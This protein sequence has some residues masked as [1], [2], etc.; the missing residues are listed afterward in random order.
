VTA[1][2]E[3]RR[4]PAQSE[5]RKAHTLLRDF[6]DQY[7]A[8]L[9]MALKAGEPFLAGVHCP[10]DFDKL[11]AAQWRKFR[12]GCHRGFDRA[13]A[14]VLRMLTDNG[15]NA[16][17]SDSTRE[18][19]ELLLRKVTDSIAFQMLGGKIHVFRT[20]TIL[21]A[22]PTIDLD[23]A[24]RNLTVAQKMNADSR[25]A[26]ALV[27]DLSASLHIG[28]LL[29]ISWEG[30]ARWDV[31]ELKSGVVNQI[32]IGY[33]DDVEPTIESVDRVRA[34]SDLS[35]GMRKQAV[36]MLKQR[37]RMQQLSNL[38][39]FEEGTDPRTQ[40]PFRFSHHES[41][42]DSYDSA[43]NEVC[44]GAMKSG[45]A[46]ASVD[47][48]LLLGA[49]S[50]EGQLRLRTIGRGLAAMH[51]KLRAIVPAI[52][53]TDQEFASM[54]ENRQS[55]VLVDPVFSNLHA[56]GC[57][58]LPTWSISREHLA[59]IIEEKLTIIVCVDTS[60]F[61]ALARSM[62]CG[63]RLSTRR[64][65]TVIA[66]DLGSFNVPDLDGRTVVL[67]GGHGRHF[68]LSGTLSRMV[69]DLTN[70]RSIVRMELAG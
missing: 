3:Q 9:K 10:A 57:K 52:A 62:G 31:V 30:R 60:G 35:L 33:L 7:I 61:V 18:T 50:G 8:M 46:V 11:D 15:Q 13:Q 34:A 22:A 63:A 17:I 48:C 1:F 16:A 14:T 39:R 24:E 38:L 2:T 41:Q 36:R 42:T 49:A 12:R 66:R 26:F 29:R 20:H 58:P 64:E 44:D 37:M 45:V 25:G 6:T 53:A 5:P 19:R 69:N 51:A 28:D 32:L 59:N 40:R 65:R 47:G 54:M 21:D 4:N 67:D 56:C 70:P 68:L 27:T 43:L 55:L 23:E